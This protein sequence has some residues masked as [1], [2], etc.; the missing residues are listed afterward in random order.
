MAFDGDYDFVLTPR[1]GGVTVSD[2]RP[3]GTYKMGIEFSSLETFNQAVDLPPWWN[4]LKSRALKS[5][6][7][8][9]VDMLLSGENRGEPPFA[10]VI[11]L[12]GFD[13]VHGC[14]TELHP[15]YALAVR[16]SEEPDSEH[17]AIMI[18]NWGDEGWCSLNEHPLL[19]QGASGKDGKIRSPMAQTQLILTLPNREALAV[20]TKKS[21][22]KSYF[23]R[24]WDFNVFHRNSGSPKIFE[25]YLVPGVGADLKIDLPDP[26]THTLIVGEIEISWT[27]KKARKSPSYSLCKASDASAPA[28]STNGEDPESRFE[29]ALSGVSDA[30]WERY[31][32]ALI[33]ASDHLSSAT[34]LP[35]LEGGK[36]AVR[37]YADYSV[38]IKQKRGK[39]ANDKY[40]FNAL[41]GT[42]GILA[43]TPACSATPIR[44]T[45]QPKSEPGSLIDKM[46]TTDRKLPQTLPFLV[47]QWPGALPD[48]RLVAIS[49]ETVPQSSDT[50][51]A[52]LEVPSKTGAGRTPARQMNPEAIRR[53]SFY[54]IKKGDNLSTIAQRAYGHQVWQRIYRAN[55]G[56]IRNPN[57]IFP[58]KNIFITRK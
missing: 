50:L 46:P 25:P 38:K 54:L 26:S 51:A 29:S 20:E 36:N 31:R 56:R 11:G 53:G 1:Q 37:P 52:P 55:R 47:A 48:P 16:L 45:P 22:F 10:I 9:P 30:Q 6:Q 14:H 43:G 2:R 23:A 44:L 24:K 17:W 35:L 18:R 58:G 34:N 42:S 12:L 15:V 7:T 3:D 41:C 4:K 21:N 40:L 49:K 13:C 39:A 19:D 8:E 33:E 28:V 27:P 32:S 57:L 5:R